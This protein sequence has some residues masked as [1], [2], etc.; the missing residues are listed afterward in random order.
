[1]PE[2]TDKE[3]LASLREILAAGE[4]KLALDVR[5]LE[6]PDSPVVVP[7]EATRWFVLL[8]AAIGAA[9]WFG[10]WFGAGVA[11][12]ASVAIWYGWVRRHLA[13]RIRGRVDRLALEDVVAWRKL[14]RI[15][16]VTL[17]PRL[18]S[19]CAAPDGNWMQF[20]RDRRRAPQPGP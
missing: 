17:V 5:R 11:A 10:G 2:R 13:R 18:G 12:A 15:G 1:M 7:A 4:A 16:G 19:P 20:V 9:W 3:L 8:A 6:H 14:W